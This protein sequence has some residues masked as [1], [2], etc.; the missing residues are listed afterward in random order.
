MPWPPR[1]LANIG[2]QKAMDGMT[3][4]FQDAEEV[5]Q[6]EEMYS[7]MLRRLERLAQEAEEG[8]KRLLRQVLVHSMLCLMCF[9]KIHLFGSVEICIALVVHRLLDSHETTFAWQAIS[10]TYFSQNPRNFRI[11]VG[12]LDIT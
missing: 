2:E 6:V 11:L 5:E 1:Q 3:D 10:C 4:A 8:N 7:G 12:K 9:C